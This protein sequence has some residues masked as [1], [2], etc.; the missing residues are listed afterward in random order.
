MLHV[1]KV[2]KLKFPLSI[3]KSIKLG[4]LLTL[5]IRNRIALMVTFMI[6]VTIIAM[7]GI[8]Y[9]MGSDAL[10][11]VIEYDMEFAAQSMA[12]KIAIT[13]KIMDARDFKRN[14]DYFIINQKNDYKVRDLDAIVFLMNQEG[15]LEQDF[16]AYE[17]EFVPLPQNLMDSIM[18]EKKDGIAH[19][20]WMGKA[21]TIAYK[22]MPENSWTYFI[23][24]EENQYLSPVNKVRSVIMNMGFAI[25]LSGM[26]LAFIVARVITKP[27]DKLITMLNK[28]AE[29]NL[30]IKVDAGRSIP[31]IY[32]LG[33]SFNGM[34]EKLVGFFR[35]LNNVIN[36]LFASGKEL[37][38]MAID[39][40][41][42]ANTMGELYQHIVKGAVEQQEITKDARHSLVGMENK[43]NTLVDNMQET[44]QSSRNTY[45]SAKKGRDTVTNLEGKFDDILNI[46]GNTSS[47][48]LTLHK[49][50]NEITS[51]AKII[52]EMSSQTQLLALNASIEAA[53]AGD[54]GMGFAVVANEVKSLAQKAS[55][56]S[57]EI[58]K[59][60]SIII[61]DT[62]RVVDSAQKGKDVVKD[63]EVLMKDTDELFEK[64]LESSL[65]NNI[66]V[67]MAHASLTEVS[68]E[69]KKLISIMG[70][71]E[72]IS[73][74][75]MI[76]TTKVKDIM[77]R[78][79]DAMLRVK[80]A[81]LSLGD[82]AHEL[83]NYLGSYTY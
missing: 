52:G 32:R 5:N 66:K 16:W 50:A 4:N 19:T 9:K 78:Q 47:E 53:R 41:E 49:R 30:S 29:G 21:Y 42:M 6:V 31:E 14:V 46:V 43:M 57:Q 37:S 54:A 60:I 10:T 71:L 75:T 81:S 17:Y 39:S 38:A 35:E 77:G 36:K 83:Q 8:S 64:I 70:E 61:E 44:S 73:G 51:F 15:V 26:L 82:V 80:E 23:A 24:L 45:T 55:D 7:G 3:G 62:K 59:L 27:I 11:Q 72:S 20:E 76:N 68:A 1:F 79:R 67:E 65:D 28:T 13:Y 58:S 40:H 25:I 48:V 22:F 56:A 18:A 69:V 74:D 12:E 63:G 2:K 33:I 34:L